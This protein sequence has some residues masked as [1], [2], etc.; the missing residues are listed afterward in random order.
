[1]WP[2]PSGSD[3][4]DDVAGNSWYSAQGLT[5][6][7]VYK[8]A[9]KGAWT[10]GRPLQQY[11]FASLYSDKT[12]DDYE[13]GDDIDGKIQSEDVVIGRWATRIEAF[14]TT[15]ESKASS[16]FPGGSRLL[17]GGLWDSSGVN[18]FCSMHSW[19]DS[20]DSEWRLALTLG[21]DIKQTGTPGVGWLQEALGGPATISQ[22]S[23]DLALAIDTNYYWQIRADQSAFP[24]LRC[25]LE[26]Y[27]DKAMTN[28]VERLTII[29]SP[30]MLAYTDRPKTGDIYLS[31]F[32]I[33]SFYMNNSTGIDPWK[34]M[35]G[36]VVHDNAAVWIES[37]P[38]FCARLD[39]DD[40]D[41]CWDGEQ[42]PIYKDDDGVSACE[43]LAV[44]GYAAALPSL[45]SCKAE[46]PA[47]MALADS[48]E[49]SFSFPLADKG[50][51]WYVGD[52]AGA[53]PEGPISC[54]SGETC[55]IRAMFHIGDDH[56][57]TDTGPGAD[58]S[59]DWFAV[60]N[61]AAAS[62]ICE[63]E[64]KTVT[65]G[66]GG[67]GEIYI[68]YGV[69]GDAGDDVLVGLIDV[70]KTYMMEMITEDTGSLTTSCQV[71]FDEFTGDNLSAWG[72]GDDGDATSTTDRAAQ[73][74]SIWFSAP[75]TT[76]NAWAGTYHVDNIHWKGE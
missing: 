22:P 8:L 17:W 55:T 34:D 74:G 32:R 35:V 3:D 23:M 4:P 9:T 24:Q 54:G 48:G 36:D 2:M 76:S 7:P 39:R 11:S 40:W 66:A 30:E 27:D 47:S 6:L 43:M 72:T 46:T 44:I 60:W 75:V 67:N 45:A 62:K 56:V 13:V 33:G 21:G 53:S 38:N 63:I 41:Y 70:G 26:V 37:A 20:T 29:G 68:S 65:T 14:N 28:M 58:A 42:V 49:Y 61:A 57:D 64:F 25:S 16:P 1:M 12:P 31:S 59:T 15:T 71:K 52:A 50:K 10:D 19:W 69:A 18:S 51:Y 5:G 73:V